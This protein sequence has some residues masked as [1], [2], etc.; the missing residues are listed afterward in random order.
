MSTVSA[1]QMRFDDGFYTSNDGLALYYCN[2]SS[3]GHSRSALGSVTP[4][5]TIL[6]LPGVSRNHRD[7][8][9][10]IEKLSPQLNW[11]LVDLRGRGYSAHDPNPDNYN[12]T[13]YVGDICRLMDHLELDTVDIIG[14]SL[15]G[16][17]TMMLNTQC[18]QRVGRV[19]IN[20]VG[21]LV[22]RAAIE[23]IGTYLQQA[24]R[25]DSWDSVV[26]AI[27]PVYSELFSG[28]S[29][30]DWH[31]LAR[32]LYRQRGDSLT[33]DYDPALFRSTNAA[34]LN[35]WPFFDSLKGK[36][37]LV[38]RGAN[39]RLLTPSILAQM[40]ESHGHLRTATI[41]DRGHAPFLDEP[42]AVAAIKDFLETT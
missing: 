1:L 9:P 15:G 30:A 8:L 12:P 36:P 11:L 17:L 7:F 41:P 3:A 16:I 37:A 34:D 33:P 32:R 20:D 21:A 40:V 39:S 18:P 10:M 5:K 19:V 28:L 25:H 13:T 23:S 26:T 4:R 38:I 35:L 29:D 6:C 24:H 2:A 14:T 31:A 27:K 42:L 22:E